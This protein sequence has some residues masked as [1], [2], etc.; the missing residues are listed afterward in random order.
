MSDDRR[1]ANASPA[2]DNK[3]GRSSRREPATID[4]RAEDL[5]PP[6]ETPASETVAETPAD[7]AA[8]T[9][10]PQAQE[11][12]G[13]EF[14]RQESQREEPKAANSSFVPSAIAGLVGAVV[15]LAGAAGW[16]QFNAS[17]PASD[18][19]I[20]ALDK[21]VAT[22]ETRIA[23]VPTSANL[24]ALSNAVS[25][26]LT[27]IEQRIAALEKARSSAPVATAGP[28]SAPPDLE[29]RLAALEAAAAPKTGERAATESR[30]EPTP[31]APA[32]PP[33]DLKPLEAR[34]AAVEQ[35]LQP[36]QSSVAGSSEAA[37][38]ATAKVD[39]EAVRTRATAQAIAAQ[40]LQQALERGAPLKSEIDALSR[41]GVA[42]DRL[43]PLN[44]FA[45]IGAPSA[46][47][48]ATSFATLESKLTE[49][50]KP[51]ADTG[52]VDR[53]SQAAQRL[54]RVRPAGE[55]TGSSPEE[56]VA[57]I[58]TALAAGNV[59]AAVTAW[60]LFPASAKAASADW[61]AQ[62]KAR[63]AADTAVR[64]LVADALAALGRK[65]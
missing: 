37:K 21:R 29:K 6:A 52:L 64:A 20:A 19:A 14:Q 43:A 41:L 35:R 62:A 42:S 55:A 61:A 1:D 4:A 54:V 63:L 49:P 46:K 47:T 45:N 58:E 26:S 24:A 2:A 65:S 50:D 25:G 13:Q 23:A 48:L 33:V 17:P 9:H 57:R 32:T 8:P 40:S 51:A 18:P 12:Q 36:L 22:V 5:T 44:A 27:P 10:E 39:E 34:I 3:T 60:D 38:A 7:T 56:L 31:A 53:L 28:A 59:A 30:I 15:A 16:Q 11:A